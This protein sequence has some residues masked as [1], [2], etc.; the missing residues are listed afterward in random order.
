MVDQRLTTLLQTDVPQFFPSIR[1]HELQPCQWEKAAP[2]FV[3]GYT[4]EAL[5]KDPEPYLS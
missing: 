3:P 2:C 5:G 1:I 4:L